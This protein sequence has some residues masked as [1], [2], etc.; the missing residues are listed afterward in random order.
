MAVSRSAGAHF[1]LEKLP[2]QNLDA[3]RSL[4][5]SM[6]LSHEA[7]DEVADFLQP[8]HFYGD[9]HRRI[10]EAVY[11][12]AETTV[13]GIDAI[14][15]A[16]ELE[17]RKELEEIGGVLYLNQILES[18]P[19]AAHARYYAEI[20]RDKFVLRSLQE[21]CTS[22]LRDITDESE[23]TSELLTHAEER[24]FHILE[25]QGEAEQLEIRDILMSAFDG[26]HARMSQDGVVSGVSTGFTRLDDLTTGL[27][28][29]SLIILAARPSMGKTAFVCNLAKNAALNAREDF[30][31]LENPS[32]EAKPKGVVIFS[33]EQSRIELAERLL[34]ILAKFD[35]HKL[36]KG[37]I[38]PDEHEHLLRS[39][40]QLGELPIYIDDQPGRSMPQ[41]SAICRRVKRRYGLGLIIIDYLQLI[42]PEDKKAP[43][44]QQVAAIARRLKFLAK[45]M[46]VPVIALAQLNR[47]VD[48]RQDKQPK[49]ADLR[50][51][52]AI[53]QDAD[54]VMFL[55]RPDAY[56]PA[57]R[58]GEAEVIVAKNRN[59]PTGIVPLVWLRES[60]RFGE[61]APHEA[62]GGLTYGFDTGDGF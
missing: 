9:A 40:S 42:E 15:V 4:L 12:L 44:E 59:G 16:E 18:V 57:D 6:L 2:P 24:I 62:V 36:R 26:I 33:L 27:H 50:E 61:R 49:L 10:A 1:A 46:N 53:E 23:E 25:Q 48:L 5:G 3:E 11:R 7:I 51:S 52:G 22:V 35:G 55:H 21:A 17:R 54:I 29:Q 20:V 43:R 60:L 41:I 8:R 38:D 34:C 47:G 30:D 19:H 28:P 13:G 39:A 37:E 45:E 32:P 14:T 58:P 31:R 56:D